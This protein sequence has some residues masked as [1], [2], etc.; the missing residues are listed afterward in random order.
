MTGSGLRS[1]LEQI[2]ASNTVT[3]M[4]TGKAYERAFR[5]H[6]LVDAVFNTI[7]GIIHLEI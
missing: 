2:N 5:G 3:H 1:L 7:Q 6:V 4:M